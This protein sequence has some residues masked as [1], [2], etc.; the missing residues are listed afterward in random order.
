LGLLESGK[1]ETKNENKLNQI[2][3][4]SLTQKTEKKEI[5]RKKTHPEKK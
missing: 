5:Q 3:I 1:N 2:W 4:K